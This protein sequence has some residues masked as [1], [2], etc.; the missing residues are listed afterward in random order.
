[1]AR[2]EEQLAYRPSECAQLAMMLEVCAWN[3]PGNVDRCHDYSDTWLEHFLATM[4]FTRLAFE[5]AERAQ[6][7]IGEIFYDAV[8]ANGRH[9]GGNTHFG[10]LL[11]LIPLIYGKGS[12]GASSA[13]KKT[14]THDAVLFYQAFSKTSVRV[15]EKDDKYDIHDPMVYTRLHTEAQTMYT[16]M[17]YSADHDMVAREWINSFSLSNWTA[18]Q[19]WAA[20]EST[21]AG[22]NCIS[23]VFL[24][25]M[26]KE[27]DTFI[28]K[29]WGIQVAKDTHEKAKAVLAGSMSP[30]AF[31]DECIAKGINPG[32]LADI[33]I[34][35]L[36]I[37]LMDGWRWE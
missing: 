37:A 5:D 14:T 22:K 23:G 36:Y 19:L 17:E 35:G 25:L 29:K 30:H 26:A 33:M 1:M 16:L 28:A 3:K 7:S 13:V 11:L 8:Q 32:S 4:I 6:R 12:I 24:Q 15:R 18:S 34:A 2:K 21:G 10:A 31:D 9:R 27:P 20:S